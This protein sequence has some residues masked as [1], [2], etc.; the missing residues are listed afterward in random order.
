MR[1]GT[2]AFLLG[3]VL[4]QQLRTLPALAWCWLLIPAAG[5]ALRLPR[6]RPAA[7]TLA[8]LLWGLLHAHLILSTA[9]APVLEGRDVT[10][11]GV[12]ASL[13]ERQGRRTRFDMDVSRLAWKGHAYPPPARVR[14]SWYG[15]AP[16]L[17]AG[18][19]WRLT[20]RLKRP[21]GYMNPGGFDYEGWLFRHGLRATGYVRTDPANRRLGARP[22]AY[23]LDR[24]RQRLS[25]T[26]DRDLNDSPYTGIITALAV[27]D[28]HGISQAQWA[29]FNGTGTTHL[30]AISGLHV[31]LVAGMVFF[32]VRRLWA[33]AVL[34]RRPWP[35]PK[36]AATAALAGAAIYAALAGFS[37]PT[38]RA[39]I[40]LA[41][42]MGAILFQRRYAA[43]FT[44]SL[45]LF[46]V[47][48]LDP[49]A[50][51]GA[52]LW[53][54][55][56]AVALIL[57]GMGGRL[58][59]RG[60]WWKWGRIHW[61][62]TLGLTPLL[63]AFFQ[64]ASVCAPL[65][66]LVAVPWVS[67]VVVPLTLTGLGLTQLAPAV[68]GA[69]LSAAAHAFGLLW[70]LLQWLSHMDPGPWL[71]RGIR[72]W[73]LVPAM[74]G[75]ALLLAPR[76][77]PSRHLGL[78]LMAPLFLDTAPKPAPGQ[79][80]FTLLDVGQGLSAVVQTH[81]HNLVYDTGPR[82]DA[83]FDTGRAVV[84][85]YLHA[86]G[87]GTLDMLLIS[88]GDNDHIGGARS[89]LALIPVRRVLTSVPGRLPGPNTRRC[90]GGQAWTWDGVRF[91]V[92][93]PAPGSRVR[94]NDASCVLR[95]QDRAG[96]VILLTG[97]IEREAERGLLH[98][99]KARLAAD[100]MTVPHHGSATSSTRAFV[101][102]VNPCYA[103]FPVGYRNRYGFPKP[104]VVARYTARG[105]R[106]YD[107]ATA[108]AITFRLGGGEAIEP[109]RQ[110]RRDEHHYWH[111]F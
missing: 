8:G 88:H 32:V 87:I 54:S 50:V 56:A 62:V 40:M 26:L 71:N 15:E 23:A 42:L 29:V 25:E 16:P 104:G 75:T 12:V 103:L 53:L 13:P 65:A 91:V 95:V 77:L 14:L 97:D 11:R 67:L 33:R 1:L 19:L 98:R 105:V 38:Q 60:L 78:V 17:R 2:I 108:G 69:C 80:W 59:A 47:L 37:I 72:W 43:G 66:N 41:V 10:I 99:H 6:V 51:M 48:I 61:L 68:A 57:Y 81:D 111:S 79:V 5:V 18:D 31:S 21:R 46:L 3:I 22:Y 110:Y 45:A 90:H 101:K 64:R 30:M 85:P 82:L 76:G 52:G 44:L 4:L 73:T 34:P 24:L 106:I 83:G 86:S 102:A 7:L 109:P 28:R 107:T 55:F 93:N 94:G 58:D 9:L 20:V 35:A 89:I 49:L 96:H 70:P 92:L 39:L 36:A 84:V 74:A 100:I 63:L 27:G